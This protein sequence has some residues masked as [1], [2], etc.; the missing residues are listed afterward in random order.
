MHR[1]TASKIRLA[2][3]C[4]WWAR[5]DVELPASTS[6]AAADLG[7]ALHRVA[8]VEA[9]D[10]A[11]T[12]EAFRRLVCGGSED[13]A[14]RDL[15][16]VDRDALAALAAAWREWWA[17]ATSGRAARLVALDREWRAALDVD[18]GAG[19]TLPGEA[20]RD[21]SA[22]LLSEIPGSHDLIAGRMP[23]P[24][25][26]YSPC[27][28]V[29]YKTGRGPHRL[30]DHEDQLLHGAAASH[31]NG[32][33]ARRVSIAVAWVTPDGV[34]YEERPVDGLELA[35]YVEELRRLLAELP[36]A[37]PR[38]GLHC[39]DFYCPARAV[40]P[41]TRAALVAAEVEIEPRRRLPLVGPVRSN[42]QALALLTALPLLEE[43]IAE[44]QR[45][46]KV[47]ADINGGVR[48]MDGRVYKARSQTRETPR[49]DVAGADSALAKVLGERTADA[50][51]VERS[52]SWGK[53]KA[54][55]KL[56]GIPQAQAEREIREALR[57]AGALKVS[58]FDTY[59]WEKPSNE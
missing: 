6:S 21:Y 45:A 49:L 2:R 46:V 59:Q 53:I 38:P 11:D 24:G 41:A 18:T 26:D 40:C 9:D 13:D 52:T 32:R 35:I 25:D 42:D 5:P 51:E 36:T 29:D 57:K 14:A 44:R 39:D 10:T 17:D 43:W 16:G 33:K 8:E 30:A 55:A 28:V 27:V 47:W 22:A 15:P 56:A 7:T 3:R 48:S 58:K 37:E 23:G 31:D 50:I 34:R 20:P 12:D 1:L 54:A 19:R 4:S